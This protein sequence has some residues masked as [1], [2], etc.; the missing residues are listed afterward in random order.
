[1]EKDLEKTKEVK[2]EEKE[3]IKPLKKGNKGIFV[4]FVIIIL[5]LIGYICYD[6]GV[7]DDLFGI[8]S[9]SIPEPKPVQEEEKITILDVE[10][11]L[12]TVPVSIVSKDAYV[13]SLLTIDNVDHS[14]LLEQAYNKLD[15]KFDGDPRTL[16]KMVK[17][18]Y[19][20]DNVKHQDFFPYSYD[21]ANNKYTQMMGIGGPTD[22][23]DYVTKLVDYENENNALN[24]YE[25][26]GFV[27]GGWTIEGWTTEDLTTNYALTT[28]KSFSGNKISK[29]NVIKKFGLSYDIDN[30]RAAFEENLDKFNTF[31]HTFKKASDGKYYWYSSEIVNE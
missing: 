27:V 12:K 18:L 16:E 22:N 5:G 6:K 1:M 23:A 17:E 20:I 13:G 24:I 19:N 26:V 14:L 7:L 3:V 11:L 8:N 4:L 25:K 10:Q 15:S 29:D 2:V 9:E 28:V 21:S 31:K 30:V